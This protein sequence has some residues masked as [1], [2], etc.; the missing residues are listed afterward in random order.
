MKPKSSLRAFLA[1]SGCALLAISSALA[2]TVTW[3]IDSGTSGAQD[4]AGNWTAGGTTFWNGASNVATTNDTTTDIALFGNGG[5]GG[6]VNVSSQSINGLIFDT[7][8]TTGYTLTA[9]SPGQ[10]LT[11]GSG[12]V[13]VNSGALATS[14]GS[15]N[16]G[17][18]INR[19][20]TWANNSSNTLT[21]GTV[22]RG[23]GGTVNFTGS[24][25]IAIGN[26]NTLDILGGWATVNGTDWATGTGGSGPYTLSAYSGYSALDLT[27]GNDI[28]NSRITASQTLGGARV[29][30]SL[31]IENPAASQALALGGNLL[32]LTS[33]G[34]LVTGTNAVQITGN[35]GATR[36]T[37]GNGSGAYD[38]VV[39][40][41]NSG[42]LTISAVIGNNAADSQAVSLTKAGTGNLTL[43]GQNTYSGGTFINSGTLFIGANST[44]T[45]GTVTSGPLGTG[46]VT[47]A[48][49]T[50]S[51]GSARTIANAIFAAAGTSSTITKNSAGNATYNGNITGSGNLAITGIGQS[52]FLSG[53]N[54]GYT[55]T[56]TTSATNT[57]LG[58]LNSGSASASWI[59][60]GNTTVDD[61]VIGTYHFGALSGG[62]SG[63]LSV[64]ATG[65]PTQILSI[66]ALNTNT[67]YAG[68]IKNGA[69]NFGT[70]AI[71]KVGAGT[72][73]LANVNTYT[74]ATTVSEG[75]LTLGVTNCLADTSNVAIG[76]GTL[77]VGAGFTDT[78]G[79][80]DC[81]GAATI[82][83][84]SATSR[85][86]FADSSDVDWTDTD[87]DG[88]LTITGTFIPGDGV[89]PGSLRF[90]D[91]TGTGLSVGQLASISATGWTNFGLDVNGYLTATPDG[92]GTPYEDWAT[93][94]EGFNDD[95]NNDGVDNGLAWILGASGPNVSA[96]D[97][98]PVISTPDGF[99]QLDFTREN[100][101]APAKLFLE[102]GNDL[103]G[104]TR[105]EIPPTSDTI[106]GDIEVTVTA[107][108][109]DAIQIKIPTA[110]HE[111]DGKLFVRLSANEN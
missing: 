107:G 77:H 9:S 47:L 72:L 39:H 109:P 29:T 21:V 61:T 55:G 88:S 33:G 46:T 86:A 20:Q 25:T 49:G 43:S 51:G 1:L 67:T 13:T 82:N 58:K 34:L 4:G 40:Q 89:N 7:T 65:N 17:I 79:T 27:A 98:L 35:T 60:N 30:N 68:V 81:T 32:T 102:Y 96:L 36:L 12:G 84:G 15:A 52:L 24:G 74:G 63:I 8:T 5:T 91:G 99:L 23:A 11:I 110:T 75:T 66:G 78:A 83:L 45:S 37:A 103:S 73:T 93:G 90:G 105:L 41:Y 10:V 54:S 42:G 100:P 3:D 26:T 106:G 44:P 97:K 28:L 48:G 95:A 69:T 111:V 56:I 6:T 14:L 71:T 18:T 92:G 85:L 94:S 50:L 57:R 59:I 64:N 80:L 16:L 101:Y 2:A 76:A 108:P 62:S 104:W 38:L 87:P 19:S 53:D 70:T 22:T 31:K